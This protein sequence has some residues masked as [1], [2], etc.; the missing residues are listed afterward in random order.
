MKQNVQVSKNIPVFIGEVF[1]GSSLQLEKEIEKL[2][3]YTDG[4]EIRKKRM[5]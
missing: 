2:I 5:F 3:A 4:G 1:R